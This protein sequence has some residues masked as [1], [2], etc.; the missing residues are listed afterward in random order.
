MCIELLADSPTDGKFYQ[1]SSWYIFASRLLVQFR[2]WRAEVFSEGRYCSTS[3]LHVAQQLPRLQ[4]R[5][6][7]NL[8]ITVGG[9]RSLYFLLLSLSL[10]LSLSHIPFHFLPLSGSGFNFSSVCIALLAL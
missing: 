8:L 7:C 2:M 4:K 9:G 3:H 6:D 1:G 10:A 5:H